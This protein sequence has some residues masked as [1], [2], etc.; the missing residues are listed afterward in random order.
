M[1]DDEKE[2]FEAQCVY[3]PSRD[4]RLRLLLMRSRQGRGLNNHSVLWERSS[5]NGWDAV[6]TISPGDFQRGHDFSRWI[7]DLY[8]I[9][10]QRGWAAIKVG[11]GNKPYWKDCATAYFHSWR[12]WD[13][14]NNREIGLLKKCDFPLEPLD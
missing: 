4:H 9:D 10:P 5:P 6:V 3:S 12:T 11:E 7:A 14:R 1:H 8:S 2:I 13:L